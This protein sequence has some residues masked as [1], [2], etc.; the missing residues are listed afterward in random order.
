MKDVG[1]PR[2]QIFDTIWFFGRDPFFYHI[3]F[4][5]QYLQ[6]STF[7]FLFS[8]NIRLCN[9]NLAMIIFHGNFLDFPGFLYGKFY[10]FR[11]HI[12]IFCWS[13]FF[14]QYI[15]SRF[16]CINKMRFFGRSPFFHYISFF[17]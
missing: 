11:F 5:I 2:L 8:G 4:F 13:L 1:F 10:I 14:M 7:D 6:L 12:S 16:Q 17:I 15:F 9:F 3:S